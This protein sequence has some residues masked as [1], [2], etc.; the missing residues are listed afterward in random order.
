MASA[1][2][3]I[4]SA[5]LAESFT[6][7]GILG[8]VTAISARSAWAVGVADRG[9]ILRWNGTAW[10]RVPAPSAAR[11]SILYAVA[12]T[13]ARSGWAVGQSGSFASLTATTVALRWDG[14]GWKLAS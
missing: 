10:Q 8:G 12:F 1:T 4:G 11:H 6:I 3:R 14:R 5:E 7:R 9:L 13:S 2:A